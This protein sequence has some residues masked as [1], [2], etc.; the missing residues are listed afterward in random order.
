MT[1]DK[2]TTSRPASVRRLEIPGFQG[3][4][5]EP[6]DAGYDEARAVYNG[7]IDRRP[8]LI[9]RCAGVDDVV[10]AVT[11][12]RERGLTVAVRGGGHN[13][14]GLGVWDDALVVDLAGMRS[15]DVDP[16]RM[17]VRVEGGA[18]LKD[19]DSATVPEGLA[20]PFGFF[21][22]AGVGGLTLGGGISPYLGRR[23]GLTI[24][25]LLEAE[26][27][28]ADGSVITASGTERPDL[29]W[30]LRGGGGNFGVVVAFTFR[31]H[32][33]GEQ[34]TVVGGPV[35]YDIADTPAVLGWFRDILPTLPEE[36]GGFFA[37]A[38]VPD[39]A[40][41][42]EELWGRKVCGIVWCWTGSADRAEEVLAPLRS[43]GSR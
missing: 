24:D 3:T 35:F 9:A 26:V 13:A 28:L 41:F 14:G 23:R 31:C 36:L 29:F 21:S 5:L 1:T 43:W 8:R 12:A 15:V 20:V 30:A 38:T 22:S 19:V 18:L 32:P 25:C 10:A 11:T 42:P 7:S 16:S 39:T 2:R 40:P 6:G 4:L 34:G 33:V 37:T 17:T 27:V